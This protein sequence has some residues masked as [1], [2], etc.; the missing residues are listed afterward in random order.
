MYLT[1]SETEMLRMNTVHWGMRELWQSSVRVPINHPAV[2]ILDVGCGSGIWAREIAEVLP[3]GQVMGVDLS[4]TVLP[5]GPGRR[6]P[7]RNRARPARR[8]EGARPGRARP[9]YPRDAH[10]P[11]R[12]P[13]GD[14]GHCVYAGRGDAADC[15]TWRGQGDHGRDEE[16]GATG[17]IRAGPPPPLS[18]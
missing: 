7:R 11:R 16:G 5:D 10:E 1:D 15:R 13:Q 9:E 18:L 17:A 2:K 3:R 6:H 8:R 12:V 14:H 4:P